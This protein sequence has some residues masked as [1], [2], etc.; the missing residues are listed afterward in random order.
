MIEHAALAVKG[1]GN[2]CVLYDKAKK[3]ITLFY[4]ASGEASPASIRQELS[5]K[6]GVRRGHE[7]EH[8][9]P[10]GYWVSMQSKEARH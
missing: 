9:V 4:E 1:L 10:R 8:D 5:A 7:G 6:V 3:E 2:A